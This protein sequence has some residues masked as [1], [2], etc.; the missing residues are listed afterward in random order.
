[1]EV[2]GSPVPLQYTAA[3]NLAAGKQVSTSS[4]PGFGALFTSGNDGNILGDFNEPTRPVYHSSLHSVGEYWQVDLGADTPLSYAELFARAG[5]DNNTTSQF[6]VQVF[7]SSMT[8]V[9][10]VVVDNSDVNGSTPGYDHTIDLAGVTGRYIR[11]ATTSDSYLSFA[12]LQ[13]FGVVPGWMTGSGDWTVAANWGEGTVPNAVNATALFARPGSAAR[14]ITNNSAIKVG[15]LRF[16][17]TNSYTIA[18]TGSLRLEASGTALIDVLQGNQRINLPTEF[19]SN[20]NI[21]LESGTVLRISNPVTVD[22]GVGVTQSGP[23]TLSYESTVTVLGGGASITF[24]GSNHVAGLTVNAGGSATLAAGN[25]KALRADALSISGRLDLKDNRLITPAPVGTASGGVYDGIAGRIQSGRGNGT[26][27]GSGIVTSQTTATN[28]SNFTSLGVATGA[29]V[30]PNTATETALWGG[31]TVTGSDTLVMYTYGG[32]ANLD[33]KIN[34]DDYGHID[35]SIGI[36]LKGWYNGDFN[37]DGVINIDDYGIIDVNI[38][39]QGPPLGSSAGAASAFAVTAVPEPG[40]G[41]GI[42][43]VSCTAAAARRWRR[44]RS[45]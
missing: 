20:T 12:E 32:D 39:I 19:A 30:L 31:Q 33:G 1:M 16:N 26:W 5:K 7:D 44:S 18:G 37:Y 27:N 3:T 34:I 13:A 11:L 10:S 28:G 36:G 38:G 45:Y 43:V 14:T 40:A 9:N 21:H 17:S 4:A 24:G 42:L 2:I 23:G 41:L 35:T 8:L 29:Q 15:T 6:D 25:N 22:S